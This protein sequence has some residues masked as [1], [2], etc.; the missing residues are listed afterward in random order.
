MDKKMEISCFKCSKQFKLRASLEKHQYKCQNVQSLKKRILQLET[1]LQ[2]SYGVPSITLQAYIDKIK[3]IP[4]DITDEKPDI[5]YSKVLKRWIEGGMTEGC[6][7]LE[8]KMVFDENQGW[9]LFKKI[10]PEYIE[11]I[12]RIIQSKVLGSLIKNEDYYKNVVKLSKKWNIYKH[13]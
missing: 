6:M 12:G 10:L 1:Q 8:G 5:I 9:I 11:K 4:H 13:L 2:E 7:K 3:V